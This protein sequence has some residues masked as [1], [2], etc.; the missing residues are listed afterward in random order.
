MRAK[1][2]LLPRLQTIFED[3]LNEG[4]ILGVTEAMDKLGA[5]EWLS[6]LGRELGA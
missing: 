6:S 1:N 4:R 3:A 5:S 2:E